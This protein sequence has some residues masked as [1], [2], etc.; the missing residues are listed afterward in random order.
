MIYIMTVA[1]LQWGVEFGLIN[2]SLTFQAS[3]SIIILTVLKTR[4]NWLIQ[5][6]IN[7]ET[8]PIKTSR[9][10]HGQVGSG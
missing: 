3:L 5:P 2:G 8:S 9:G 10:V 6:K 4:L 1:M 7:I